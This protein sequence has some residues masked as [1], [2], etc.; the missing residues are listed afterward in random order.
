MNKKTTIDSQE[1]AKFAQLSSQ[2]WNEHGPL[3]TL[4][5]INPARLQFIQKFINLSGQHILDVG[6]GGGILAESMARLGAKVTGLDAEK[7]AIAAASAHANEGHLNIQY[8]CQSIETFA[9][10]LF[11]A[12]TCMEMLE[13][14]SEPETV[15]EHCSRL[16]KP[17]GYLFLSTINRTPAAY[18]A[19]IIAAEYILEL[20]PR[21]THEFKKF[22][23][24]SE[25]ATMVREAGL[26]P[27]AISGMSYNPLNHKASLQQSVS[28]NYLLACQKL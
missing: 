5:D 8:V 14:V 23:K 2:W 17:G 10:K 4:H 1:I 24:P 7:D 15:I 16:V 3:K 28:V 19:A 12:V 25:L 26:E 27:I 20:L 6:C 18:A 22:I 11:D 21:Q 13:H 9:T